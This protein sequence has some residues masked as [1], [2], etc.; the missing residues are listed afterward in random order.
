[1]S[2]LDLVVL[3]GGAPTDGER[4]AILVAGHELLEHEQ[5][6]GGLPAAYRS[7]WRGAG[8]A[9]QLEPPPR[10]PGHGPPR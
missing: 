3:A 6:D 9:A 2:G 10:P 7:G 4:A 1:M 5:V 8:L